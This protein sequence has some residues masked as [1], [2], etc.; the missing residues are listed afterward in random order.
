M[1][2]NLFDN[3]LLGF[4]AIPLEQKDWLTNLSGRMPKFVRYKTTDYE[5]AL[6]KVADQYGGGTEIWRLLAPGMP[7]KHFYP[8]QPKHPLEAR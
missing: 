2:Q 4:N 6:N 7:F 1:P 3:V 8:R 5:Y